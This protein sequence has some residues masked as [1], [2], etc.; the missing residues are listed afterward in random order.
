MP[1]KLYKDYAIEE[2]HS[3]K[4]AEEMLANGDLDTMIAAS[5]PQ[6]FLD[7]SPEIRRLFTD[8]KTDEIEYYRKTRIFP[9]MHTVVI[10]EE[11]WRDQPWIATSLIKAFQRAKTIAYESLNARSAFPIGLAWIRDVVREQK[12][13]L[14]DDPWSY[15]FDAN[16]HVVDTLIGHMFEQ[17]LLPSMLK[18]EEVFAPNTLDFYS[19]LL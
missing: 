12:A 5:T 16:K 1:I 4:V 7:G 11:I 13:V 8:S 9:I 14:G 3:A 15:G 18:G 2:L 10:K 17:G 19:E 6:V